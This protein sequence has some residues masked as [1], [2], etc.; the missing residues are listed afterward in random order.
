M[1]TSTGGVIAA[2]ALSPSIAIAQSYTIE[3]RW[4]AA[5]TTAAQ[6]AVGTQVAAGAVVNTSANTVSA[7]RDSNA[8]PTAMVFAQRFEL[9]A[10]VTNVTGQANSGVLAVR[11]TISANAAV[12]HNPNSVGGFTALGDRSPF[13]FG[14]VTEQYRVGGSVSTNSQVTEIFDFSA[15]RDAFPQ[16]VWTFNTSTGQPNPFPDAPAAVGVGNSW[17]SVF[18]VL[19]QVRNDTPIDSVN[20]NVTLGDSRGLQL[21]AAVPNPVPEPTEDNPTQVFNYL[22][23]QMTGTRTQI[24]SGFTVS[25]VP[26]PASGLVL[27]GMGLIATRRRRA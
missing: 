9:Q 5:S 13:T 25:L 12:V 2:L 4:V 27:A 11:G 15:D 24:N 7:L 22:G 8:L 20:V 16:Q 26:T 14:G 3:T 19:V 17:A 18:R 21:W 23:L 6:G 10:R 1:R